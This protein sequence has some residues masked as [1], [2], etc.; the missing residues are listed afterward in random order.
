MPDDF[1]AVPSGRWFELR[2]RQEAQGWA[3]L[4]LACLLALLVWTLVTKGV[5]SSWAD[6]LTVPRANG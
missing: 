2:Q 4:A 3:I 1:T 6:L 5:L